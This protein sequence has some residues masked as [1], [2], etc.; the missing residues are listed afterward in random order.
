LSE[1]YASIN[2]TNSYLK[3]ANYSF[4]QSIKIDVDLKESYHSSYPLL[5]LRLYSKNKNPK[6]LVSVDE[7]KKTNLLLYFNPYL[8]DLK[9]FGE[10][11]PG[12][13]Y[14][15]SQ[16]TSS[17]LVSLFPS[18]TTLSGWQAF[19]EGILVNELHTESNLKVVQL[20]Q[21]LIDQ[22]MFVLE[23]EYFVSNISLS[24]RVNWV[25][26]TGFMS[27]VD[28]EKLVGKIK[29]NNF[30]N[31]FKYVSGVEFDRLY[32]ALAVKR[33]NYSPNKFMNELLKLGPVPIFELE[34]QLLSR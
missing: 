33:E 20:R 14:L 19:C 3:N 32:N 25:K 13:W 5:D 15:E 11:F 21:K 10:F 8:L 24:E 26:T 6:L 28:A 4:S 34:T 23:Y 27:D 1:I 29:H 31:S 9:I 17:D 18:S 22:M 7:I 2:R 16:K 30:A 12:K